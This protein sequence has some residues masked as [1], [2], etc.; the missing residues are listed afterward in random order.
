MI[1]PTVRACETSRS[2]RSTASGPTRTASTA[3]LTAR[4]AISARARFGTRCTGVSGATRSP[5]GAGRRKCAPLDA[6][7]PHRR[8]RLAADVRR[9][10]APGGH[11]L[12]AV[13]QY[14][15]DPAEVER[16]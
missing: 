6:M 11:L 2:G 10:I 5:H 12:V 9:E 3:T 15:P 14:S 1:A 4:A 7:E 13:A 16:V 8:L